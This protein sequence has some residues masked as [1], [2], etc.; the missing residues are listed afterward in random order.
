MR[1]DWAVLMT[2]NR[3]NFGPGAMVAAAFIGP[4]TVTTATLAGG[5]FGFTLLWAVAFSVAATLV[6]QEMTARLGTVGQMGLGEAIAQR[7]QGSLL[8]WPSAVLVIGAIFVGNA[9]YEAGN[10]T[11]AA[12]GLP[13][14]NDIHQTVWPIVIGVAALIILGTGKRHWIERTLMTLVACMALVFMTA[15]VVAKPSIAAIGSGLFTP[16]IPDNAGFLVLGLIGTT[17]VPYN[18]FL[19]ASTLK[20]HAKAGLSLSDARQD[21]F[22]SVLGGGV[23]TLCI[24][25]TAAATLHSSGEETRS[26]SQL[27]GTLKP[28]LGNASELF[29]GIGFFAAGLSSAITAPLAAAFAVTEV[30]GLS[31]QRR[32]TVFRW[33]WLSVLA[34]GILFASLNLKPIQLILFAQVANGI[35]LPI[36]ATFIVWVSND[37]TLLGVHTNTTT[38]NILG[39][40]VLA[41][42]M[43]LGARGIGLAFGWL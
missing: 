33:V 6:L 40:S 13:I 11:G 29:M 25:I 41:V 26:L 32:D 5:N 27:A 8:Y 1:R 18:L 7:T 24:V 38:Q 36:I 22:L 20:E 14:S 35:L 31:A 34:T 17:V 23:I 43:L 9:A 21:I 15:A 16:K 2:M 30:L 37:R 10:I 39:V 3:R 42:T 12:A 4:G 19:H 28:L